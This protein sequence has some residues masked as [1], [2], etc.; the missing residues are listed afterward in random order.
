MRL[1]PALA[2]C[3]LALG[4][5]PKAS[6]PG[7][8]VDADGDGYPDAAQLRTE[9]D[10]RAF[11]E[12]F[13]AVALAQVQGPEAAFD[14]SQRDCAGLVRYA[15]REALKRHDAAFAARHPGLARLPDVRAFHYPAVPYLKTRLF[16]LRPGRFDAGRVEEDFGEA[17]EAV[18][19][20]EGSARRLAGP[21]SRGDLALFQAPGGAAHLMIV[22]EGG[23][24]PLFV[25]HTGPH[26]DGPGDVRRA[27]LSALMRHPD[28]SWR[29]V[30]ANPSFRGYYRFRILEGP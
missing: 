17:P 11:A 29:P 22:A 28:S 8:A 18:R 10:R 27:S 14:P 1:A 23:A 12:A 19:L 2:L 20:A 24:D 13:T 6:G 21:P 7:A 9:D 5:P 26:D 30:P 3:S 4:C 16:R 25:Y 15:Y